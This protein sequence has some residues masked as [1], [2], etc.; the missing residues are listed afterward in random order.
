[1][2]FNLG[3]TALLNGEQRTLLVCDVAM[4]NGMKHRVLREPLPRCSLSKPVIYPGAKRYGEP[5]A[6]KALAR[7]VGAFTPDPVQKSN[8][9]AVYK[10]YADVR[11][12]CFLC[13]FLYPEQCSFF[14]KQERL[15]Y[16]QK[17]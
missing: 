16:W 4:L 7:S 15:S 5:K 9:M 3:N 11:E 17:L 8:R 2:A 14:F 1:L 10:I 6:V 13:N 12:Y